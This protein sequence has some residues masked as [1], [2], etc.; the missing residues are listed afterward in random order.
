M[1]LELHAARMFDNTKWYDYTAFNEKYRPELLRNK[2]EQKD[3]EKHYVH[4][5][6]GRDIL[7][8]RVSVEQRKDHRY[9]SVK[10]YDHSVNNHSYDN[11]TEED[12]N[13]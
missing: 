12:G 2:G 10:R 13:E 3:E 7:Y 5:G 9:C 4:H 11:I 8:R 6:Q 1:A